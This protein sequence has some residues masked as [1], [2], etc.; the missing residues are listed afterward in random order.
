MTE[1]VEAQLQA[2]NPFTRRP[3]QIV[4]CTFRVHWKTTAPHLKGQSH[5]IVNYILYIIIYNLSAYPLDF[6]SSV[7]SEIFKNMSFYCFYEKCYLITL[8]L[9]N[10]ASVITK[11]LLKAVS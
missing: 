10:A 8:I 3:N 2:F 6:F 7:I 9:V 11:M 4:K 5:R 1:Q